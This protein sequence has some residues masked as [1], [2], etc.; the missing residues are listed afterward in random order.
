VRI[1]DIVVDNHL[2][3]AM[4]GRRTLFQRETDLRGRGA[5]NVTRGHVP[6]GHDENELL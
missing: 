5:G 2:R 6:G 1:S 3:D 4:E